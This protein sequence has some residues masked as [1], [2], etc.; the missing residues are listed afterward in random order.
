M[1]AAVAAAD[2]RVRRWQQVSRNVYRRAVGAILD[3]AFRACLAA[4]DIQDEISRLAAEVDRLDGTALRLRVGSN[5]GQLIAGEIG[6]GSTSY[7]AIG[8]QVGMAQRMESVAPLGG[9]ML[10]E[11]TARLVEHTAVPGDAPHARR[12]VTA[13][14]GRRAAGP[15]GAEPP[16]G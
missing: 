9:V 11:S 4:L 13:G 5:S 12:L 2:L 6:S 1:P 14:T 8:E 15:A 16:A 7:T 10:N 3:H